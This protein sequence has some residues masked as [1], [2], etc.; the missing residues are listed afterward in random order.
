MQMFSNATKTL[1]AKKNSKYKGIFILD[2]NLKENYKDE[3]NI[4]VSIAAEE[5]II[6]SPGFFS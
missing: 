6:N 4:N 2:Q 3:K 5:E 1:I